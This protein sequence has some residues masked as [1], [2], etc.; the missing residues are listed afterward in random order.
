[1]TEKTFKS[2]LLKQNGQSAVDQEVSR[3]HGM[4]DAE[5]RRVR[6][7][8]LWTIA[9]W[10]LWILMISL[11]LVVPIVAY[12]AAGKTPLPAGATT[13]P[14]TPPP[15]HQSPRSA[16]PAVTLVMGVLIVGAFL[17]L[18]IAGVVLAIMLIVSRRTASLNQV[19]A[20][21]AA[22]DAQLRALGAPGTSD[23]RRE[24]S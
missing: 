24:N 20:S 10:A 6:R 13:M 19:R 15:T 8:A 16:H 9:V 1:M 3:L 7:L 14:V 11:S 23:A 12:Q 2:E 22:I 18:P 17:G 5:R 4:I 21:L